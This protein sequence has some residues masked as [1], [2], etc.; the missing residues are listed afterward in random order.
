[1]S[2]CNLAYV[3]VLVIALG[4]IALCSNTPGGNNGAGVGG[5]GG[6]GA[7]SMNLKYRPRHGTHW[8][9][10]GKRVPQM[11]VGCEGSSTDYFPIGQNDEADSGSLDWNDISNTFV[12]NGMYVFFFFLDRKLIFV[13]RRKNLSIKPQII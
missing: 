5:N 8:N 4:N 10:I 6:A 3:C 9:R 1:M 12:K 11:Q 7:A 13:Q 2:L